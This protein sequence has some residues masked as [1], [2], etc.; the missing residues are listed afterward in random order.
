MLREGYRGWDLTVY[1]DPRFT[2]EFTKD[3]KISKKNPMKAF[4]FSL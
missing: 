1:P 4:V 3:T 2:T